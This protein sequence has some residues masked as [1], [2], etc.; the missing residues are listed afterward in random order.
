MRELQSVVRKAILHCT[1]PVIV[2]KDLPAEVRGDRRA[3]GGAFAPPAA[4][5]AAGPPP[6]AALPAAAERRPAP[7][8]RRRT[9]GGRPG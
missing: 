4:A 9:A 3:V 2:P 8:R 7:G 6:A 1:G 5:P